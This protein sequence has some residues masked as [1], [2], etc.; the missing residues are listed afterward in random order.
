VHHGLADRVEGSPREDLFD[1]PAV[2]YIEAA[3][4]QPL[5]EQGARRRAEG[6]HGRHLLHEDAGGLAFAGAD[7]EDAVDVAPVGDRSD[8]DCLHRQADVV[9]I[10][11][12]GLSKFP[13][14]LRPGAERGPFQEV[15]GAVGRQPLPG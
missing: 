2:R 10:P 13:G 12:T 9:S 5:G 15:P 11:T 14:V 3:G 7:D 1:A 8:S 6:N 4:M